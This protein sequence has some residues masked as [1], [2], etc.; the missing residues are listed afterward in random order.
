MRNSPASVMAAMRRT[1]GIPRSIFAPASQGFEASHP[2]QLETLFRVA[3]QTLGKCPSWV[4]VAIER[5]EGRDA[6]ASDV[7]ERTL[8]C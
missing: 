2:E 5:A 6:H 7:G 1:L 3:G 8:P 4:V